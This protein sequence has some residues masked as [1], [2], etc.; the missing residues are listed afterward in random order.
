MQVKNIFVNHICL[1]SQS[2]VL[3]NKIANRYIMSSKVS[4]LERALET[5]SH[6]KVLFS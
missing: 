6:E 1:E 5:T 3:R 4:I 2:A